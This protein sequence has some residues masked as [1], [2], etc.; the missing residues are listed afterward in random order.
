MFAGDFGVNQ[1]HRGKS[2]IDVLDFINSPGVENNQE[3]RQMVQHYEKAKS[4]FQN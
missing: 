2:R 3:I 4:K 1:H